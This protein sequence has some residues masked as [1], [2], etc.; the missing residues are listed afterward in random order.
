MKKKN[1]KKY[2][3]KDSNFLEFYEGIYSIKSSLEK[4]KIKKCKEEIKMIKIKKCQHNALPHQPLHAKFGNNNCVKDF[5]LIED[6]A[7]KLKTCYKL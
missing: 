2:F 4:E 5:I 3:T 1:N 7:K 6:S